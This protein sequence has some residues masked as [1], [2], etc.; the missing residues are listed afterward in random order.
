VPQQR[1]VLFAYPNDR[2]LLGLELL[3]KESALRAFLHSHLGGDSLESG[4]L[5][6]TIVR[7]KPEQRAVVRCRIQSSGVGG[8][9]AAKDYY[10]RIFPDDRGLR[11]YEVIKTLARSLPPG[12]ELAIPEPRAFDSR[13]HALLLDALAGSKLKASLAAGCAEDAFR[14]TGRALA[15]LHARCGPAA[16][17][18]CLADHVA[19]ARHAVRL[20][21]RFMPD[22]KSLFEDVHG[23][24]HALSWNAEA[25]RVGFV[26]G[27]FHSGQVL[28]TDGRVGLVDFERVHNGPVLF[29]L[30]NWLAV[31]LCRRLEGK[32]T[33]DENLWECFLEG[34]GKVARRRIPQKAIAWWTAIALLP[35]MT[36]PLRR[37][38]KNASEK[39]AAHLEQLRALL[40]AAGTPKQLA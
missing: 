10:V 40:G 4:E 9:V 17:S 26:H 13:R 14:R 16:A 25:D 3:H 30:G 23:R 29:D 38:D 6:S 22:R 1:I 11:E 39:V 12:N 15:V 34:Y 18:R 28:V 35:M 2:R 7:Y 8:S 32:W 36:K 27:D 31:S 24:L 19:R 5:V 33:A 21:S 20:L 37:L